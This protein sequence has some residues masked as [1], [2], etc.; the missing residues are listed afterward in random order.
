MQ[1]KEL[2]PLSPKDPGAG[3]GP[4]FKHFVLR[5]CL[6]F[7]PQANKKLGKQTS[8]GCLWCTS[9]LCVFNSPLRLDDFTSPASFG[10]M[11]SYELVVAASVHRPGVLVKHSQDSKS[12]SI[13]EPK[14]SFQRTQ[15]R[16]SPNTVSLCSFG[17]NLARAVEWVVGWPCLTTACYPANGRERL[18]GLRYFMYPETAVCWLPHA[19][20]TLTVTT[21]PGTGDTRDLAGAGVDVCDIC[22][23][24]KLASMVETSRS[25]SKLAGVAFMF[26][27]MGNG[28]AVGLVDIQLRLM[29]EH[30]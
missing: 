16:S 17:E 4:Q 21:V 28:S 25:L 29:V 1:G 20:I 3:N 13:A 23:G 9:P 7:F 12:L 10:V 24:N 11:R 8:I 18:H 15:P 2:Y 6:L 27:S 22:D 30:L 19:W 14:P 5:F 26:F